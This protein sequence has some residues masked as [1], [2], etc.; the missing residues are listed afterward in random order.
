MARA[1]KERHKKALSVL[2][3]LQKTFVRRLTEFVIENEASLENAAEGAEG[4][5]YTLHQIDEM[6]LARLNLVERAMAELQKLPAGGTSRYRTRCFYASQDAVEEEINSRLER[7]PEA[8][9]LGISVS[10]P[11]G[12]RLP[13]SGAS[14]RPGPSRP[15]ASTPPEGRQAEGARQGMTPRG[16]GAPARDQASA[17]SFEPAGLRG[18]SAAAQAGAE[19]TRASGAGSSRPAAEPS[20]G[21][22]KAGP[23][24]SAPD[25]Q[26]PAEGA[27]EAGAAP[28]KRGPRPL[29]GAQGGGRRDAAEGRQPSGATPPGDKLLVTVLYYGPSYST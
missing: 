4:Y 24:R 22:V 14:G 18:P 12:E 20:G 7:L 16:D 2:A 1:E 3:R 29:R 26:R 9:I 8:R 13:P 10:N 28:G 15:G 5:G 27:E 25:A 6:F 19:A 23:K 21:P 17:S 11:N